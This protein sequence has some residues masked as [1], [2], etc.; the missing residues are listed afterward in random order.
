MFR[1]IGRWAV[2]LIFAL[3]A[4]LAYAGR[5]FPLTGSSFA[6]AARGQTEISKDKKN[7][8][9]KVKITVEHLAPPEN[10]SPAKNG[11]L[12]WFQQRGGNPESQGRLR[13]DKNLKGS[14]ETTTPLKSFDVWITAETDASVTLPTGQEVLRAAVQQ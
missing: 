13:I 12:V 3:F 14:F 8:N 9:T 6:P 4:S 1:R 11:Y 7:G 5:K 2:I 10:L